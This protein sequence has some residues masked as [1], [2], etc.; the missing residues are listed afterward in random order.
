VQASG[1]LSESGADRVPGRCQVWGVLNV[2]PDSFSDGGRYLNPA[3]ALQHAREML[4]DGADV[5]DVG[6]ASS[7]PRGQLYGEGASAISEAEELARIAPVVA[8]VARELGARVSIDTTQAAV[9]RAAL[10]AGACIVNDVSG[11]RSG[12]LLDVTA[13]FGAEC[14][15]MHTRGAGEVVPPNTSYEDVVAEVIAALQQAVERAVAHGVAREK[16]WIDPGLGFAKTAPQSLQLLARTDALVAT[17]VRVLCGPSRK[18]FIAEIAP[19][20]SGERPPPTE[21]EAGTLSAVTVAV[22]QGASAV[23]VHDVAAAH[24]AVLLA[25]A[26]RRQMGRGC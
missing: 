5:I 25:D 23:R 21:R 14:V 17:G 22:L 15:L 1:P 7:R 16:L 19:R 6:G 18:G 2:T 13:E 12:A 24:Q 11:G 10:Q 8:A 4:A 9:A 26:V 3:H 20:R